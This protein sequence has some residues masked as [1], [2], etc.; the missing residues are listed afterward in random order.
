MNSQLPDEWVEMLRRHGY[1][2]TD[3][4]STVGAVLLTADHPYS[5]ADLVQAVQARRPQTGRASVYR[6]LQKFESLGLA[7]RVH[8]LDRCNTYVA[9]SSQ[10]AVLFVCEQ[11]RCTSWLPLDM[12]WR[13][14]TCQILSEGGHRV[15]NLDLQVSGVCPA[16]TT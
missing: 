7:K 11:C 13:D 10:P 8:N 14:I 12:C 2:P 9:R 15:T 4:V 1:T 16:C 3:V 5:A 6:A